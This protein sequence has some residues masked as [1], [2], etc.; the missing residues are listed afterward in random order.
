MTAD[1]I[2]RVPSSLHPK[3]WGEEQWLS[4]CRDPKCAIPGFDLLIKRI[5]ANQ[6]LSVQVHPN[7]E[8]ARIV[9]GDMKTEMWCV[10]KP[11]PLFI[12]FKPGIS[13]ADVERSVK[14]GSV[15]DLLV[16]F[17]AKAGEC[18]FIPGGLVHAI[19]EGTSVFEVQ[20]PSDTTFRFYDWGR[21][22]EDGRP[23]P[24]HIKEALL[25]MNL[26][27]GQVRPTKSVRC[28]YFSFAQC[29]R[30]TIAAEGV[31]RAVYVPETE[32]FFFLRPGA[33]IAVRHP[34]LTTAAEAR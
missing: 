18:Y 6:R 34:A 13:A 14:D 21:V 33:S 7:E 1:P 19:G 3:L 32:D 8:T 9:G 20:Q 23:R 12:G 16:R 29:D 30:G 28:K 26:S 31:Y 5:V 4:D 24:L 22:G 11:G 17:E 25:A 2:I 27:L 15:G 10:L